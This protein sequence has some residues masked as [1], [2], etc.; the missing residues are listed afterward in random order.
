[1]N[2]TDRISQEHKAQMRNLNIELQVLKNLVQE[3]QVLFDKVVKEVL[4]SL[5]ANPTQY[6][7]R[8][9]A[10]TGEWELQL[11]PDVIIMPGAESGQLNRATRRALSKN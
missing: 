11:R 10:K 4:L 5:T 1:M 8:L 2:V 9:E 3:R 7:L 6:V